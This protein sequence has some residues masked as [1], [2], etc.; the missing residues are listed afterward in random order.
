MIRWAWPPGRPTPAWSAKRPIVGATLRC[1]GARDKGPPL[2]LAHRQS[3]SSRSRNR[4][5]CRGPLHCT[6]RRLG[7]NAAPTSGGACH[8]VSAE[9]VPRSRRPRVQG[10]A[11]LSGARASARLVRPGTVGAWSRTSEPSELCG[12]RRYGPT[13]LSGRKEGLA[14]GLSAA[15]RPPMRRPAALGRA[16]HGSRDAIATSGCDHICRARPRSAPLLRRPVFVCK[17]YLIIP[18]ICLA[19]LR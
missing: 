14:A 9:S 7:G 11:D 8:L 12:H 5:R 16:A 6:A 13:P 10:T 17:E 15:A 19:D 2:L 3:R 18:K 1:P 4:I